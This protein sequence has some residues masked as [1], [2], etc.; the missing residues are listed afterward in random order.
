VYTDAVLE[1]KNEFRVSELQN[2]LGLGLVL[3]LWLGLSSDSRTSIC[4]L[5]QPMQC[6]GISNAFPMRTAKLYV[7]HYF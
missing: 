3:L 1:L 5:M 4:I 7:S 2:Q 6:T